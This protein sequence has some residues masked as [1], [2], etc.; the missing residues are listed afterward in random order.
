MNNRGY[1]LEQVVQV[2]SSKRFSVKRDE[3]NPGYCEVWRKREVL[4][5]EGGATSLTYEEAIELL[6]EWPDVKESLRTKVPSDERLKR[7]GDEK[8]FN[9]VFHRAGGIEIEHYSGQKIENPATGEIKFTRQ[10]A[11]EWLYGRES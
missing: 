9:V 1:R 4:K 8:R 5:T 11:L 3:I 6:N 10:E 7:L 2:A